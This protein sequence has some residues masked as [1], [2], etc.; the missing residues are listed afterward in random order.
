MPTMNSSVG[1]WGIINVIKSSSSYWET[2]YLLWAAACARKCA[3]LFHIQSLRD[4]P[5]FCFSN[6]PREQ[7]HGV[8]LLWVSEM[9]Q[10]SCVWVIDYWTDHTEKPI[11]NATWLL[12]SVTRHLSHTRVCIMDQ[13]ISK[14]SECMF[15]K[16]TDVA[17]SQSMWLLSMLFSHLMEWVKSGIVG[18][19]IVIRSN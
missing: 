18:A 12:F 17:A 9:T 8:L 10:D 6:N 14:H 5:L 3:R 13:K 16:L 11:N 19:T 1:S 15:P 4:T 2:L 7:A